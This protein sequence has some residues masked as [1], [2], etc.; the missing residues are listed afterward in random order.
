MTIRLEVNMTSGGDAFEDA[1][2]S[3]V[4]RILREVAQHIED[5]RSGLFTLFD[6]NG[7]KCGTASFNSWETQPWEEEC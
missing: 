5:G 1:P 7:N 2:A 4:A 3:E 6:I